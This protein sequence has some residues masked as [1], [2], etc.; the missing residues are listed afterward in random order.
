MQSKYELRVSDD[1]TDFVR[2]AHPDLRRKVKSALKRILADPHS[3]K[4]LRDRLR[5][6]SSF[7]VGRFRIIYRTASDHI[8]E[9]AAIG[10]RRIIYET[11]YRI[12]KREAQ[13]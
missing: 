9:I 2:G 3:G 12:I 11:T 4:S 7:R 1:L 5:G 6:L 10:P 8:I 13:E